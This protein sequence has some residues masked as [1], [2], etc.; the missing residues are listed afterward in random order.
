MPAFDA[1]PHIAAAQRPSFRPWWRAVLPYLVPVSVWSVPRKWRSWHT[2]RLAWLGLLAVAA[3]VTQWFWLLWFDANGR[4]ISGRNETRFAKVWFGPLG[5]FDVVLHF[6]TTC[7]DRPGQSHGVSYHLLP[8]RKTMV[9][10]VKMREVNGGFLMME[11]R[12]L[13]MRHLRQLRPELFAPDGKWIAPRKAQLGSD[14]DRQPIRPVSAVLDL[15]PAV[16]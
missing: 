2:L 13:E 11:M 3:L 4:T 1:L 10:F 6:Q 9:L 12:N 7:R 8:P 15:A 14:G 16:P 5:R